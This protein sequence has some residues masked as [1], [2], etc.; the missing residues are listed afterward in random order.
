[1]NITVTCA[2]PSQCPTIINT[3]Q[4][5]SPETQFTMVNGA[6]FTAKVQSASGQ[7]NITIVSSQQTPGLFVGSC[8]LSASAECA[9]N[10]TI[11]FDYAGWYYFNI[12]ATDSITGRSVSHRYQTVPNVP[13][14]PQMEISVDAPS[15]A[16]SVITLTTSLFAVEYAEPQRSH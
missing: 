15:G 7:G 4:Q 9:V 6:Q 11:S 13:S 3:Y 12:I 10:G 2:H 1:M 16:N 5:F 14:Q 8:E